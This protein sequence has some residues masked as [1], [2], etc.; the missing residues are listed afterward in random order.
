MLV[1]WNAPVK[2][3]RTVV[4]RDDVRNDKWR[5]VLAAEDCMDGAYV[6][7]AWGSSTAAAMTRRSM[8]YL[9]GL[10]GK[11]WVGKLCDK[12]SLT[13]RNNCWSTLRQSSLDPICPSGAAR[14]P[15]AQHCGCSGHLWD[16]S[17]WVWPP[18]PF[19][20]REWA[21]HQLYTFFLHA[22][23]QWKVWEKTQEGRLSQ[24]SALSSDMAHMWPQ[25][26]Q[27][28]DWITVTEGVM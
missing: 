19:Q 13:L 14:R 8:V 17:L 9:L 4:W 7:V 26:Q 22:L 1:V 11:V 24:H 5:L 27:T 23:R 3:I 16:V 12:C 10:A 25:R 6:T 20:K 2:V 21:F 18:L 15:A 28:A